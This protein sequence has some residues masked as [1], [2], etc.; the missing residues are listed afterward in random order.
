MTK[1][2]FNKM[3]TLGKYYDEALRKEIKKFLENNK[4]DKN[5]TDKLINDIIDNKFSVETNYFNY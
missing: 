4:V 1:M 2:Q 5:G 3:D